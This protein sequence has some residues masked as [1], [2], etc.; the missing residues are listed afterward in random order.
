MI[1]RWNLFSSSKCE[2]AIP[3]LTISIFLEKKKI[4]DIWIEL[5]LIFIDCKKLIYSLL[6][7]F[8]WNL[9][10]LHLLSKW[11]HSRDASCPINI[12]YRSDLKV[13]GHSHDLSWILFITYHLGGVEA[14]FSIINPEF[15]IPSFHFSY[16]FWE[17]IETPGRNSFLFHRIFPIFLSDNLL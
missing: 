10:S 1:S 3:S 13:K 5:I 7:Y 6:S 12:Y 8:L 2:K 9:L 17:L 11:C 15:I 16:N 14:S 4:I